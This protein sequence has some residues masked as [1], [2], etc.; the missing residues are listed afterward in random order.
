MCVFQYCFDFK[1]KTEYERRSRDGS[2]DVCS[3]DLVEE[4]DN[5][6]VQLTKDDITVDSTT[7]VVTLNAT[8]DMANAAVG[9]ATD[10]PLAAVDAALAR[11]DSMRGELGRS[12]GRRL[13]QECV[14]PF[15]SRWSPF[16]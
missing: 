16:H 12:A 15:R 9:E 5:L 14:G 13:G 6:Y 7:G 1:Q 2:S 4:N 3:S 11:V 10:N 8:V